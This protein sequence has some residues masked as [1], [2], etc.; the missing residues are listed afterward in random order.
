M[1]DEDGL[2]LASEKA[3][4]EDVQGCFYASGS[5]FE[6]VYVIAYEWESESR[7]SSSKAA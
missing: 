4:I 6:T 5:S 3:S 7:E 2:S 1:F